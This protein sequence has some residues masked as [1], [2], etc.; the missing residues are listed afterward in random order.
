MPQALRVL[1]DSNVAPADL[2]HAAVGPGLAVYARYTR[3]LG[4]DD[5][6]L[7]V[8]DA[9]AL[10]TRTLHESLAAQDGNLDSVSRWA[11]A[12]FEQ[13]GFEA[14]DQRAA[15][16]LAEAMNTSVTEIERGGDPSLAGR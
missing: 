1:Q 4:A 6:P 15:Q 7:S 12:W 14:G 13:H 9:L 11:L 8:R 5:Q 16:S 2:S 10:I 3:V